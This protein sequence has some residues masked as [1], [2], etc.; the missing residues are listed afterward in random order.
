MKLKVSSHSRRSVEKTEPLLLDGRNKLSDE[1]NTP[2]GNDENN[3]ITKLSSSAL[4]PSPP[5][6]NNNHHNNTRRT[7]KKGFGLKISGKKTSGQK[8]PPLSKQEEIPTATTTCSSLSNTTTTPTTPTIH[9]N[10][11]MMMNQQHNMVNVSSTNTTRKIHNNSLKKRNDKKK[12]GQQHQQQQ[13]SIASSDPT[14]SSIIHQ[15]SA[16]FTKQNKNHHHHNSES[17]SI[18]PPPLVNPSKAT[19]ATTSTPEFVANWKQAS[20]D[21]ND[22]SNDHGGKICFDDTN[23]MVMVPPS[24]DT[25]RSNSRGR[26]T[27][28]VE[29]AG[30]S[31]HSIRS[32][33]SQKGFEM[34]YQPPKT[35]KQHQEEEKS[36]AS[37]SVYYNSNEHKQQQHQQNQQPHHS[38]LDIFRSTPPEEKK[39]C[40]D[41]NA[42][43][44]KND[45]YDEDEDDSLFDDDDEEDDQYTYTSAD[46]HS[47]SSSGVHSSFKFNLATG[48]LK[49][50]SKPPKQEEPTSNEATTTNQLPQTTTSSTSNLHGFPFITTKSSLSSMFSTGKSKAT[51]ATTGTTPTVVRK[52]TTTSTTA[53]PVGSPSKSS[54]VTTST[55][56]T[57]AS[58]CSII[59]TGTALTPPAKKHVKAILTRSFGRKS[60]PQHVYQWQVQVSP[61][62]WDSQERDWKYRIEVVHTTHKNDQIISSPSQTAATAVDAPTPTISNNNNISTRSSSLHHHHHPPVTEAFTWR[63]LKSFVWLEGALNSE[64]QGGLV[65]PL[66]SITLGVPDL[67]QVTHE[68]DPILLQGWLSDIV[69]GIRGQG[70]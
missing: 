48:N 35:T 68:V 4:S 9:N 27:G 43:N 47:T 44:N 24:N 25:V 57:T 32:S 19:E 23:R 66:L 10:M 50:Q 5:P 8:H 2:L 54:V 7:W 52:T 65:L 37:S 49:Q 64:F 1:I 18:L 51:D 28:A 41:D 61:A 34:T 31:I 6:N 20:F 67:T 55:S 14:S 38:R 46:P 30:A 70:I 39:E 26:A 53:K 17:I 40:H 22:D 45:Y 15:R 33:I 16:A 42:I 11:M 12:T 36:Q 13:P 63:S 62:E 3:G 56:T 60:L 59:G 21:M 58:S 29:D 69:N